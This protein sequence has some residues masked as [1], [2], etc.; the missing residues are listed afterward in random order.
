[1]RKNSI[2]VERAIAN[3]TQQELAEKLLLHSPKELTGGGSARFLTG[4]YFAVPG[5]FRDAEELSFS[6]VLDSDLPRVEAA[7]RDRSPIDPFIVPVPKRSLGLLDLSPSF[8]PPH[9]KVASH[10]FYDQARGFQ[11]ESLS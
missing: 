2:K 4:G 5:Q 7:L 8:L 11:N 6:S 9:L 10:R 3:L 1:M